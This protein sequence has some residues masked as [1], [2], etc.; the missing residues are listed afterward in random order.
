MTGGYVVKPSIALFLSLMVISTPAI[1]GTIR[2]EIASPVLKTTD[3]SED[4]VDTWSGARVEGF[5]ELSEKVSPNTFDA[6]TQTELDRGIGNRGDR[7]SVD[8][9][10]MIVDAEIGVG[11]QKLAFDDE[12]VT[13]SFHAKTGALGEWELFGLD[14][15]SEVDA[16]EDRLFFAF[17]VTSS[18][19]F[20][21]EGNGQAEK[22]ALV[23]RCRFDMYGDE[24][25]T[26]AFNSADYRLTEIAPVPLPATAWL[27]GAALGGLGLFRCS[28]RLPGS[29]YV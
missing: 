17:W 12:R 5:V 26:A 7:Y 3:P 9:S 28:R 14:A 2:Y 8:L 13:F 6:P 18:P 21:S 19:L 27:L 15:S 4:F 10:G 22:G 24:L 25:E 16:G 1:S 29:G 11:E 20:G 23:C